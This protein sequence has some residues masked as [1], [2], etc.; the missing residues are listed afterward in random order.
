MRKVGAFFVYLLAFAVILAMAAFFAGYAISNSEENVRFVYVGDVNVSRLTRDETEELLVSRGLGDKAANP[1]IVTTFRGERFAVDPVRAGVAVP[2]ETLVEEAH[3]IA[4]DSDII[5]NLLT[6][7][8]V[9]QR[10]VDVTWK[11]RQIDYAYLDAMVSGCLERV[12]GRLA[13]AE[14]TVDAQARGTADGKGLG[15]TGH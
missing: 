9:Y 15:R 12:Q 7:I 13:P 2:V 6:A 10:P 3:A 14:Y 8:E 4:H 1:L 5:S 11:A